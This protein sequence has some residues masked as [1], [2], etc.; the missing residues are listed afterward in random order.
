MAAHEQLMLTAP[1]GLAEFKSEMI[2]GRKDVRRTR[3]KVRGNNLGR[4]L[5]LTAHL[6]QAALA[7]RANRE[8][9]SEI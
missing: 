4:P 3:A 2:R 1:G 8:L 9:L 6:Q 7:R 5:K